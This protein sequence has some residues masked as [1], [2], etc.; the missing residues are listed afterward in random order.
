MS[1]NH[2]ISWSVWRTPREAC[3]ESAML[4]WLSSRAAALTKK[5]RTLR[6]LLNAMMPAQGGGRPRANIGGFS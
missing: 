1:S 4:V 5:C 2:I 3:V 6:I